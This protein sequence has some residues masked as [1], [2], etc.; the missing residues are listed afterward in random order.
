M[1]A[2]STL[3]WLLG[4]SSLGPVA[5]GVFAGAQAGGFVAAGGWWAAA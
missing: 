2:P 3:G 4:L 5:G 1:V